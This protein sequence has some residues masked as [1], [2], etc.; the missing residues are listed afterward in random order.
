[1][2]ETI[3]L[4]I[5]ATVLL[6]GMSVALVYSATPPWPHSVSGFILQQDDSQAPNK[7][8]FSLNNTNNSFYYQDETSTPVP[9]Y[10]GWY[11]VVVNGSNGDKIELL[12][13]NRT[14]YGNKNFTLQGNMEVNVTLNKSRPPEINLTIIQPPS[15]TKF[16]ITSQ[17]LVNVSINVLG[18]DDATG[19]NFTISFNTSVL[20]LSTG[21]SYTH[22]KSNINKGAT[23]YEVWML[24]ASN[25]GNTNITVNS[26]CQ[27]DSINFDKLTKDTI[28][29]ISVVDETAPIVRIISPGNNTAELS[30][31]QLVFYYNVSDETSINNCTLFVNN[32]KTNYTLS[33][34]KDTELNM[35]TY[36]ANG[37]YNWTI[38]CTDAG[39][40]TGTSGRYNL[41]MR[42]Y[43]PTI[44]SIDI[45]NPINLL[46][47][48]KKEV[49][50]NGSVEDQN[51]Y[52]D[53]DTITGKLY[54]SDGNYNSSSPD[55]NSNHYSTT[56]MKLNGLGNGLDFQCK[57]NLTYYASPGEWQC[58]V[59]VTD[60]ESHSVSSVVNTNV[61][62][63]YAISLPTELDYGNIKP[64]AVS[65]E[66]QLAVQN[67]GN[68]NI[69]VSVK[70]YGSTEGDGLAMVCVHGNITISNEHYSIDP[71]VNFD[72]MTALSSTFT[73]IPNFEIKKSTGTVSENNTYWKIKLPLGIS[74]NCN[75]TIEI[76]VTVGT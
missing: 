16:N 49:I 3:Q 21:E 44:T 9:G 64:G 24:T 45:E 59:T 37:N 17:V 48:S 33:P 41:S 18:N 61:S 52:T 5:V 50:C 25:L 70:G 57:F 20:S 46:A 54:F 7:V 27:S 12:A 19:C 76:G 43:L 23:V 38:N 28:A 56:C 62:E 6:L 39:N 42:V 74:G 8:R 75:G 72:S 65:A 34:S 30:S 63:L 26:S 4:T 53:I 60:A 36:L 15:D 11:S 13:W 66:K 2:R 51:G 35:S 22:N 55:N 40:N 71:G 31:N 67:A 10:S 1:M 14:H 32:A 69:N 73:L 29:N 68:V 58:N 47:G